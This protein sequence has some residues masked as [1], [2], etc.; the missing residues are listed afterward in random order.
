MLYHSPLGPL[1]ITVRDGGICGLAFSPSE[2]D[3]CGETR[4]GIESQVPDRAEGADKAV[5]DAAA[6]WLTTYF[7]GSA[8]DF[9]PPL[10]LSGTVFQK[11]VWQ[12]LLTVPYGKTATYGQIARNLDCRSA[13]A[14]GQAIHDNSIA[15][16]IPCHRIIGSDGSLT[17][18]A[19]GLP[20]KAA[21][22]QHEGSL[23]L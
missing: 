16:I 14:V 8:P 22:L 6:R 18:Y 21:L 13:Q 11:R 10:T 7:A 3:A 20:V 9:L 2:M 12:A 4:N 23:L 1:S 15:I 19:A 5:Y 17:G